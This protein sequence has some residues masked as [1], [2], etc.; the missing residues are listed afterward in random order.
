MA[1]E[2]AHQHQK[3]GGKVD[4]VILLDSSAKFPSWYKIKWNSLKQDL[5]KALKE[6]PAERSSSIGSRLRYSWLAIGCGL[7]VAH[8]KFRNLVKAFNARKAALDRLTEFRDEEG[9]PLHWLQIH[10]FYMNAMK[11][12]HLRCLDCRGILFRRQSQDEEPFRV[13]DCLGW[14]DL[15]T[16]GL[17]IIPIKAGHVAMIREASNVQ[18]LARDINRVLHQIK[19]ESSEGHNSETGGSHQTN[20]LEPL[21][22]SA[23]GSTH[24]SDQN[25]CH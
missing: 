23:F 20:T 16:R 11:H 14:D 3:R 5:K 9:M 18:M 17:E 21:K 8:R 12:Y 24:L 1:F 2:A 15:F 4:L 22:L 19:V 10:R 6:L 13:N 25:R 7:V